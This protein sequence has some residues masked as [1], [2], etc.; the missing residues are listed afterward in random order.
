MNKSNALKAIGLIALVA[1]VSVATAHFTVKHVTANYQEQQNDQLRLNPAYAHFASASKAAETDFT[2]AAE[3]SV[4]AVVHVRTKSAVNQNWNYFA[5]PLFDFYF[6]P[7][8]SRPQI[9]TPMREGAGSGVIITND[10]YIVTNN[11]VVEGSKEIEITLNDKRTFP[12]RLIGTDPTTDIAL[13]KIEA[14]DLPIIP[15]G[16]SDALKIGEWVL[17]VGNPFNLTST[18]TA[19]IVSAK[20]RNIDILRSDLKIESFI[21]TDAAINPGNSG[22]ALVNTRGELIGINTAIASQTGTFAGC[23]FAVPSSIVSKVMSDLRQFGVVQRAVLGVRMGDITSELAKEKDLNTLKGAYIGEVM[24]ESAAEKAGLKAGDVITKINNTVINSAAEL[25]EQVGRYR[26]GNKISIEILRNN[27]TQTVTAE[28]K[29][30][31]GNTDI[32]KS[33]PTSELLGAKF[34]EIDSKTKADL[35]LKYGIQ[36]KSVSKGK[37]QGHGIKTGYIILRINNQPVYSVNELQ[38]I[39]DKA[40]NSGSEEE[41]VLFIAGVY[42]NG[43]IT[44]YAINLAD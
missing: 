3:L 2:L 27:K 19:G 35:N 22:G 10:G 34:K 38:A 12:A 37:F 5:D 39:I 20:A 29:N 30:T 26:P 33:S 16:D 4:H 23:G 13:L 11:H 28:L 24:P 8:M 36:V 17:A 15:F 14:T 40:V 1:A 18:V 21:Q 41:K 32:V 43:R 6:G 44:H 31:L 9:E 7:H 25:Q 42:P